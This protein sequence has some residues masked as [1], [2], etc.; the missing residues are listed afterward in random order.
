[1]KLWDFY[2]KNISLVK[3]KE[4]FQKVYLL[5]QIIFDVSSLMCIILMCFE[6]VYLTKISL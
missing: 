5:K 4:V 3:E 1:M 2:T 6:L